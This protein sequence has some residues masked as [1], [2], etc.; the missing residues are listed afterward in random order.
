MPFPAY[1]L[2]QLVSEKVSPVLFLTLSAM[3]DQ[4]FARAKN[5]SLTAAI[6]ALS[7]QMAAL[8]SKVDNN[9]INNRKKNIER[10]MRTD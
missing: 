2:Y 7:D 3:G 10:E 9:I 8:I 6:K 5:D 1:V 4:P